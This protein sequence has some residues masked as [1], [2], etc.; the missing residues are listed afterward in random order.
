MYIYIDIDLQGLFRICAKDDPAEYRHSFPANRGLL[1]LFPVGTGSKL[2][3]SQNSW[4]K[5]LE[6]KPTLGRQSHF[7]MVPPVGRPSSRQ[8]EEDSICDNAG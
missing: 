3:T 4:F 7:F 2:L 1:S 8:L 5:K 6:K